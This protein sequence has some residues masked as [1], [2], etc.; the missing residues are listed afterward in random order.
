MNCCICWKYLEFHSCPRGQ[1]L[2]FVGAQQLGNSWEAIQKICK[3]LKVQLGSIVESSE[4]GLFFCSRALPVASFQYF[5]SPA[6]RGFRTGRYLVHTN[7]QQDLALASYYE[8]IASIKVFT[9]MNAT[10]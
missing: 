6:S 8:T 4:C 5:Q 2:R 10:C 7:L 9:F 1:N 3:L